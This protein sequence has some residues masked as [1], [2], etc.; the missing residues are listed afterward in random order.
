MEPRLNDCSFVYL[1]P[2]SQEECFKLGKA[3]VVTARAAGLGLSQFD[4]AKAVCVAFPNPKAARRAERV[5]HGLFDKY[6]LASKE[7]TDG[8]TEWFQLDCFY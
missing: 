8:Y 2:S 5:L 1:L 6:R 3:D 7:R 4:L